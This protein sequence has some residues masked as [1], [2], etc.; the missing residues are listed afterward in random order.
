MVLVHLEELHKCWIWA[1]NQ[2]DGKGNICVFLPARRI[3]PIETGRKFIRSEY[4]NFQ[5]PTFLFCSRQ[6]NELHK[7]MLTC[8]QGK[9]RI[10][11]NQLALASKTLGEPLNVA[12]NERE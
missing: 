2:R 4:G 6:P 7:H 1:I 8:Q 3:V 5:S 9:R 10:F 11:F 12:E